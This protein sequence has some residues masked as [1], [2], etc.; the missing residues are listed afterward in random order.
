MQDASCQRHQRPATAACARC[1]TFIC[2]ECSPLSV[3][4]ACVHLAEFPGS[5]PTTARGVR[6]QRLAL[7]SWLGLLVCVVVGALAGQFWQ[8]LLL[9]MVAFCPVGLWAGWQALRLH[10]GTRVPRVELS[11]W[12]GLALNT[13]LLLLALWMGWRELTNQ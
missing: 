11:A 10:R 3:C 13:L 2:E 8:P 9:I 6:A 12:A 5:T 1:G 7:L 4:D